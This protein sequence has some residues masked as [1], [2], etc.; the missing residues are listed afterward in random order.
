MF[1]STSPVAW[2]HVHPILVHFTTALLPVS[3][4]SDLLGKL[5]DR[6]SLTLAAWWMLLYGALA[7]P[8]TA[9][10]GWMWSGDLGSSVGGDFGS[11]LTTHKWLG[12]GLALGF[13][14]LAL[15]RGRIFVRSEKPGILYIIFA[16]AIL[17]A[18]LYQGFLG[19]KMTLG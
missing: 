2:S 10:A 17:T 4:A 6:Y 12:L 11:T 16:G 14:V 7:T 8:L 13:V 15:W 19:G 3:L 9:F 18:L 1:E 5:T